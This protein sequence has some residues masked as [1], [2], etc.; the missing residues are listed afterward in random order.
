M[1]QLPSLPPN[2]P[3]ARNKHPEHYGQFM[4]L[5]LSTT[6][7]HTTNNDAQKRPPPLYEHPRYRAPDH[8][9][10]RLIVST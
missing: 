9:L 6:P 5:S 10:C 7:D 3:T 8:W 1:E 2:H 4:L